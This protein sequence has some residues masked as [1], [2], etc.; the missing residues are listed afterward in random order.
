MSPTRKNLI[1]S[2]T[3]AASLAASALASAAEITWSSAPYLTDGGYGQN[4]VPGQFATSG[5]L[6]LAENV[7]G[8]ATS[9]DGINFASG[10]I[11]FTGGTFGGFHDGS[12]NSPLA[13]TGA[14]GSGGT[15]GTVTL[16][17]LTNGNTY[18]IQALIYDGRGSTGIVGRTISFDGI[19]QGQYANGISN[20]TWG[21]GLLVTGSFTADAT[22]Q[23][24]TIEGFF[25]TS[26]VG[27]QLN[28]IA[29]HEFA[30]GSPLLENPTVSSITATTAQANIDLSS[31]DADVT[32]YWD[33]IDQATGTWTNS[34]PLGPQSI[35]PVTGTLSDLTG[36]TLYFF[37]FKAINTLADPPTEYWSQEVSSFATAL[38]GK[39]PTEPTAT[40]FSATEIDVAWADVFD[41]ETAFIIE[42][43]PDGIDS[44]TQVGTA[45]ANAQV[46]Y[47]SD[48]LPN[49]TYHYRVTA[50]NGAGLSD[51][52]S[53]AN[54]TTNPATPGIRVEAWFRLGD[55]GQ[56]PNN[57]PLDT[58]TNARNFTGNV[59]S[60]TVNPTGGGYS[61]DAHYTFNGIDQG[62]FGI[63]YNAPENNIGVEV[64]V[65]TSD[66]AQLNHHIFGT[67]SNQDGINIGYDASDSRGW[68]GA[69]GGRAFVG[70]LG[71]TN[72]TANEWIHLAIVRDS[73]VTTFY[74]NG[75]PSGTSTQTP[76]NATAPHL[77]VN[78]G[79]GPGAYFGGDVAEARIFTFDPGQF[80][81]S[82]LLYPGNTD[83][84]DSWADSFIDLTDSSADLDFDAGGLPTGIE[85]VTGGDPTDGSDD[86]TVSPT[87]DNTTD[88]D[89]F[90]F[91]FRRSDAAAADAG[92]TI[93][94]E[95]GT[96][97]A[98]WRNTA[99]H[100][101]TDGVTID[102]STDLG[103]GF[104]QVTVSIPRTLAPDGTLFTRLKVT[105][106]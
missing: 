97:L 15:Q 20:V 101:A 13:R 34:N 45:P 39:A 40:P 62:Y 2:W 31:V 16:N 95:Y 105:R 80:Q 1:H 99:D 10:T 90:L 91:T 54:A 72:Y 57:R 82:L 44:W 12:S 73:G 68:F 30:N 50:Q 35:G 9:F 33:T 92:T 74:I 42:R 43:S 75:T 47:D 106:P 29:V 89:N 104:H 87:F 85:W 83:P 96:D 103:G 11:T 4:L 32:L 25:G 59:N 24:F 100:G 102:D 27:A 84:F 3:L 7:G 48:L 5:T 37:R 70:S 81:T 23:T 28:A 41:T 86:S 67:G 58:S 65:R 64:W 19:N 36:D 78:A 52:S 98:T 79:G 46:F 88:P 26:S 14:Y 55:D 49:T 53:V 17:G 22:S 8:S 38:T 60:A 63:N 77:A 61:N 66:L 93:L 76:F 94:V 18:R 6:F 21:N 71:T 56:G 51:P 69:I